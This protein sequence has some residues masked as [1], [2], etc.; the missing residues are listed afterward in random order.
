MVR[1]PERTGSGDARNVQGGNVGRRRKAHR[2]GVLTLVDRDDGRTG[3]VAKQNARRTV[4]PVENAAHLL[5]GDHKDARGTAADHEAIG[6]VEGEDEA[7]AGS[8]DVER[9]TVGTQALGDGTRL[10][11]SEMVACCGRANDEVEVPSGDARHVEGAMARLHRKVIEG[12]LRADTAL[13]DTRASENPL[14]GG[15]KEIRQV[16][17]G[18]DA[19]RKGRPRA[20]NPFPANGLSP[21]PANGSREP[22]EADKR[23]APPHGSVRG[24]CRISRTSSRRTSPTSKPGSPCAT[25]C[26]ASDRCRGGARR[27]SRPHRA[28]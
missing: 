28:A 15:I 8:R 9:R 21:S 1:R 18:D 10:R 12:L 14:V 2:E 7:R 16:V 5:R 24:A 6:D 27:Q 20:E 19:L 11:G 23:Y 17:V 26:G 13:L 22:C 25:S 4:L 3:T